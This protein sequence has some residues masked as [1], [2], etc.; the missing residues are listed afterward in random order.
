[1]TDKP[2]VIPAKH[3][4]KHVFWRKTPEEIRFK[5]QV[6]ESGL[7]LSVHDIR[8]KIFTQNSF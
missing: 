7:T 8:I 2:P 6:F 5:I 4:Y 1:M 3:C